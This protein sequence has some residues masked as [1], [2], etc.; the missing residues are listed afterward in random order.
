MLCPKPRI[1]ISEESPDG[2]ARIFF[3]T[4]IPR[5]HVS[6]PR[7]LTCTR[8]GP[9]KDALP[10]E[11]PHRG[12]NNSNDKNGGCGCG[13]DRGYVKPFLDLIKPLQK[14]NLSFFVSIEWGKKFLFE[15]F[16]SN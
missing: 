11:L 9:L 14:P 10:T 6:N 4:L 2:A 16:A 8:L 13:C 7:Q 15:R 5:W 3:L 1:F 12:Q